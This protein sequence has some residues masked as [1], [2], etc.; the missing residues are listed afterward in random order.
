MEWKKLTL[1]S[2]QVFIE[3]SEH[4][5]FPSTVDFYQKLLPSAPTRNKQR[6]TS[7]HEH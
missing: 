1:N 7:S 2:S 5:P 4:K 3:T 6:Y